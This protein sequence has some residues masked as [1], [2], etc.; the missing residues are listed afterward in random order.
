MIQSSLNHDNAHMDPFG[1]SDGLAAQQRGFAE[2]FQIE[3]Y[4]WEQ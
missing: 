3:S 2:D 1:G 4:R